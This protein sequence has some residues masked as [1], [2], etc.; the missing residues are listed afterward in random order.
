MN[1]KCQEAAESET[2]FKEANKGT[3][4]KT[5]ALAK[6]VKNGDNAGG[7]SGNHRISLL[8]KTS[9]A[10]RERNLNEFS[11]QFFQTRSPHQAHA[12]ARA[13]T[14]HKVRLVTAY[15]ESPKSG[16]LLFAR[17]E[18]ERVG[19][20][21]PYLIEELCSKELYVQQHV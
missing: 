19:K 1:K 9:E 14:K 7:V 16:G 4:E 17:I 6:L 10:P 5:E 12:P 3:L 2:V 8:P 11:D 18:W 13:H 20:R 21:R 15:Q